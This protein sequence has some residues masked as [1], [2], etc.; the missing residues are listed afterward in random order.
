MAPSRSPINSV[1]LP[2][3]AKTASQQNRVRNRGGAPSN[4]AEDEQRTNLKPDLFIKRCDLLGSGQR[5]TLLA[6]RLQRHM[7]IDLRV[8][9]KM[10]MVRSYAP[11][12]RRLSVSHSAGGRTIRNRNTKKLRHVRDFV[13]HKPCDTMMQS[14][15]VLLERCTAGDFGAIA[16]ICGVNVCPIR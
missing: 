4:G 8:G 6:L 5:R 11:S 1:R 9:C 10:A 15:F 14:I 3:I 13:S 7:P 16:M 12:R 2:I